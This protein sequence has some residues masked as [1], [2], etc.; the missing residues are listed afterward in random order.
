MA[1]RQVIGNCRICRWYGRLT[2][3]HVPPACAFNSSPARTYTLDQWMKREAEGQAR[4][5][6]DQRGSGYSALCEECNSKRGGEW[7]VPESKEWAY[8]GADV[9]TDVWKHPQLDDLTA[10]NLKVSRSYPARFL[11][12]VV[13]MLLAVNPVEFGDAH[14]PLRDL[15]MTRDAIGLPERYRLYLAL[16]DRDSAQH[17]GVYTPMHFGPEGITGFDAT[18]ILYPPFGYTLTVGEPAPAEGACEITH[19]A[20]IPIDEQRDVSLRVPYN[21]TLMPH[22]IGTPDAED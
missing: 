16:Y 17:R 13:M 19:F 2:F 10:V 7:Y 22:D 4:W 21:W 15:V 1:K 18:D 3:E 11:K 14:Q 8:L 6:N 5:E 9:L 20:D 12:Q